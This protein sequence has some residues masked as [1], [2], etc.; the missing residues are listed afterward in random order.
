[1]GKPSLLGNDCGRLSS[2]KQISA[3]HLL[4]AAHLGHR[5]PGSGP[6][7]PQHWPHHTEAVLVWPGTDVLLLASFTA[8]SWLGER[9]GVADVWA[10]TNAQ[11]RTRIANGHCDRLH[12]GGRNPLAALC[13]MGWL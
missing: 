6:I 13:S 9:M 11:Y 7:K 12:I 8:G 5:R 2:P 3:Q 4:L 1:M 10:S